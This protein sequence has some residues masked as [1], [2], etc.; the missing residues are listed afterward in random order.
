MTNITYAFCNH[1]K[2]IFFLQ[3]IY[4]MLTYISS[5]HIHTHPHD[6]YESMKILKFN[7]TT[8]FFIGHLMSVLFL[9]TF[10]FRYIHR[11]LFHTNRATSQLF[12]NIHNAIANNILDKKKRVINEFDTSLISC[13]TRVM[14]QHT[15]TTPK[16]IQMFNKKYFD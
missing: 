8:I 10:Y 4:V 3:N 14:K 7:R 16:P 2:I 6:K 15:N 11:D 1:I 9:L 12:K 5:T 13:K